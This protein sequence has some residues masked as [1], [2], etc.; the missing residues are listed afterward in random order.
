MFLNGTA[1]SGQKDHDVIVGTTF[2]G[3][4]RTA[5]R[6]RFI[7]VRDEFPGLLPVSDGGVS[8]EGELY[9][10]PEEI[11]DL[12]M[13]LEPSELKLASIEL[14]NGQIVNAMQLE[15]SRLVEG[16]KLVDIAEF[17]GWRA[18]Q[19]HLAANARLRG[20]LTQPQPA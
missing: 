4:V 12:L 13:P 7:A 16:D 2:L 17:G 8:I 20:V 10:L 18:Y 15:P 11:L 19:R 9:E 1:M 14:E 5:A 3:P 6:Y